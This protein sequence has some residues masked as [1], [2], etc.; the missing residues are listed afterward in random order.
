MTTGLIKC[1]LTPNSFYLLLTGLEV[2]C[3]L[4]IGRR[5]QN[6][7]HISAH[8]KIQINGTNNNSVILLFNLTIF[9][10]PPVLSDS[11]DEP[12]NLTLIFK[13]HLNYTDLSCAEFC[14]RSLFLQWL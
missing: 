4:I 9:S 7:K 8:K 2:R 11:P 12:S 3:Y 10:L 14:P 13:E 6:E 1:L 5:L